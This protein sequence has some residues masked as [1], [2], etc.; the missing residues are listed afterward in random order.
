V[1]CLSHTPQSPDEWLA[2]I[3]TCATAAGGPD[4]A[5]KA[6]LGAE[7]LAVILFAL[8]AVLAVLRM[9]RG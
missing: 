3:G 7:T 8:A 1:T 6:I 9:V 2:L 5:G 4:W